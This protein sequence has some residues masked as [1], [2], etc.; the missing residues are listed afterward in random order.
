METGYETNGYQT[1][2]QKLPVKVI[3][4]FPKAAFPAALLFFQLGSFF[5]SYNLNLL[6][7]S[8][9]PLPWVLLSV[10]RENSCPPFSSWHPFKYLNTLILFLLTLLFPDCMYLVLST[11]PRTA[12]VPTPF[13]SFLLTFGSSPV[14]VHPS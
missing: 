1:S 7:C 3:A 9:Y 5:L 14:S 10:I 2:S 8:L 12:C 13:S 6:C 4:Q 11:P